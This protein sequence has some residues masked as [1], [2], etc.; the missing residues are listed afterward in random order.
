MPRF[1]VGLVWIGV[2]AGVLGASAPAVGCLNGV[3]IA[4]PRERKPVLRALGLD[5]EPIPH[6]VRAEGALRLDYYLLAAEELDSI[7][8]AV[9][10]ASPRI[11][12]RF[13]RVSALVAI[14]S[15]GRWPIWA[16]GSA[17][18][19]ESEREEVRA[20]ALRTLRGR[21]KEAPDDPIRRTDLG[22]GLFGF[23]EHHGE[24]RLVLEKLAA[25][26]LITNARAYFAL[27]RLRAA[28]GDRTGAATAL[29]TCRKLDSTGALCAPF[30]APKA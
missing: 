1:S 19:N 14:R 2:A 20:E 8:L 25:R 5:D 17:A 3:T 24:A 18:N 15:G 6:L 9:E 21:V 10:K 4:P 12:S 26:D 29:D 13:Q 28:T 16:A 30:S 11:Q 22:L 27:S 7:R 23:L